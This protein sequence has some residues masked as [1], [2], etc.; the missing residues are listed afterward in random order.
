[1]D[2]SLKAWT[3]V[4]SAGTMDQADLAK[5]HMHQ[6][7]VQLGVDLGSTQGDSAAAR[8]TIP[9]MQ[10]VVRYNVTPVDGLFFLMARFTYQLQLRYRGHVN[11]K[12]MQVSINTGE[13]T[14]LVLFDSTRFPATSGFQLQRAAAPT[15]SAVLDFVNNG[16]YVEATLITSAIVIGKPSAISVIQL[17]ATPDFKG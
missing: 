3:T 16:Y 13:E 12:F 6:S 10:A 7:I 2:D 8:A 14:Q 9:T 15:D 5:V 1:M 4:G 17:F 11:A